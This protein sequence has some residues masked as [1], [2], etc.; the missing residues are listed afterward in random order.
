AL[1][2]EPPV[3]P[4]LVVEPPVVTALVVA[5]LP[6]VA[7]PVVAVLVE[8]VESSLVELSVPSSVVELV[9]P[10]PPSLVTASSL[11]VELAPPELSP[12]VLSEPL[13][14]LESPPEVDEFELVAF[15]AEVLMV[16]VLP[17]PV[18]TAA[19][20]VLVFAV[21]PLVAL[22]TRLSAIESLSSTAVAQLWSV[23]PSEAPSTHQ[24][25]TLM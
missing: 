22:L 4:A 21:A 18:A 1:V 19:V 25:R 11:L 24:S 10:P 13:P 16:V 8:V 17:G 9:S 20:I 15:E 14:P 23:S 2:V 3:V 12:L 5:A 6:V 7:A